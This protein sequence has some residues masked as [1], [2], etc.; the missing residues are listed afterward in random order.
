MK[1]LILAGGF[2]TR[3]RPLSCTK[4]KHLLPIVNK[5]LLDWTLERLSK[6][7]VK[8]VILAVNHGAEAIARH[9]GDSKYGIKILYSKDFPSPQNVCSRLKPLGTG[10]PIKK[11][12]KL[13]GCDD[14]F[15][16]LNGDILTTLNY[17]KLMQF[18]KKNGGVATIALHHVEDP[19]RY[20]VVELKEE[21]SRVTRFAEKP[22]RNEAPSNLVN[23]GIYALNPRIFDYIPEA[24]P[25]SI[26]REIFP[27]LTA[28][29]ALVGYS[30]DG[31]WVDIGKR[32]DYLKANMLF[33]DFLKTH[34]LN[35]P[36]VGIAKVKEPVSIAENVSIGD[37]TL[38]PYMILGE[39][40]KVG[41]KVIIQNS[42]VF[43]NTVISDFAVI[44]GAVIG[45][46]VHI[47]KCVKIMENCIV[48]DGAIIKDNVALTSGVT[49]CPFKEVSES[50]FTAKCVM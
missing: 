46:G 9:C 28:E 1:A 45:E 39:N 6:S 10:G 31:L 15:L 49:V 41:D 48:G 4:P 17:R 34:G 21:N 16:V 3:L 37:S 30:F 36:W 13:L 26:E 23:A 47:G 42:V 25:C 18:H 20:G 2:G 27:K 43:P 40:V 19:S 24:R 14:D 22:S 11:A 50:V 38:G 29:N 33:L 32:E 7:G 44:K 35:R 8:E 5:P 12:E